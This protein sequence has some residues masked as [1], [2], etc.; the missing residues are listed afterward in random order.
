M[1]SFT[2]SDG[3]QLAYHAWGAAG[4]APPVLLHHGFAANAQANWEAPGVVKAL[5]EAGR[6][7]IAIV[8]RGHGASDKPH[9]PEFY[10]EARMARDLAELADHLKLTRFDLAGY[11]MGA[12]VSLIAATQEPRIRKLVIGGIGEGV[13]ARGGVDTRVIGAAAIAKA[14]RADDVSTLPA[15]AARFR[16]FADSTGAD[17]LALAAHAE[18]VHA[19]PI[20]LDR[21]KAPTLVIAGDAD[22]LARNPQALAD[23]I[24]DAQLEIVEGDH[25]RAVAAPRFAAAIVAFLA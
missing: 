24:P 1:Q 25:L 22:D 16:L 21:I 11:S 2:S 20:P 18:R 14:M 13:I 9:D 12:I 23:A 10:G 3:L 6:Q 7:A 17:R 8:A 15:A 4:D 19:A 5:T